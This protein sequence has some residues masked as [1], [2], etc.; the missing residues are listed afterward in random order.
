MVGLVNFERSCPQT[1]PETL[2]PIPEE[3]MVQPQ[4]R[5]RPGAKLASLFTGCVAGSELGDLSVPQFPIFKIAHRIV[6]RI[7]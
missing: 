6:V 2:R 1:N 4:V 7:Q 5:G 3:E